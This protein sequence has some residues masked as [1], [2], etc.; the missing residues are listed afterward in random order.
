M[1]RPYQCG[2]GVSLLRGRHFGFRGVQTWAFRPRHIF[3]SAPHASGYGTAAHVL[4]RIG[5]SATKA[6]EVES[7]PGRFTLKILHCIPSFAS[8][9]AERQLSILAPAQVA[10]GSDVHVAYI[11]AGSNLT[12]LVTGGV[13]LHRVRAH[14]NHDPVIARQLW[15]LMAEV[16]PDVV[17]TWLPQM[18]IAGGVVALARRVPWVLAERSCSDAYVARFKDRVLRKRLGQWADAAVANSEAGYS[19]WAKSLRRG[20]RAHVVRNVVPLEAIAKAQPAALEGLGVKPNQPVAIF[21]G[22]LSVEKNVALLLAA[23]D[24]VCRRSN[25]AFLIC[26]D[27]PLRGEVEQTIRSSIAGDQIKLLGHRDDVWPLMKASQAFVSTSAFEGQPNAVL[28]AMA[29]GCPLVVSDIPAHREFL[30]PDTAE[31]VPMQKD[32]FVK[33]LLHALAATPDVLARVERACHQ[34]EQYSATTATHNYE[35]IYK[36]VAARHNPCVA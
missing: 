32:R 17:H 35:A 18:D 36:E 6:R 9:G 13:S 30:R 12:A 10:F 33:G 25:A 14:S 3:S 27:G 19:I 24:E 11:Y 26:G 31:I 28:E 2:V 29:C 20:A 23:A 8:G 15:T 5:R 1:Y 7:E 16:Q 21:V 34:V 4:V 22:R